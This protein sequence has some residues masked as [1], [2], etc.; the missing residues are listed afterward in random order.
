MARSVPYG[1][2]NFRVLVDNDE[3]IGGFSDVSGLSAEI[4]IAEYRPGNATENHVSKIPGVH[5]FENVTLKRGIVDSK[6]FWEWMRQAWNTGPAAKRDV[7]IQMLD[8]AHSNV[9]QWKLIGAVPMKYTGPSLAGA[10]GTE[11]AM[12]EWQ[13]A[14][15]TLEFQQLA[16]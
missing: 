8:E 13:I 1:N 14:Y 15:D 4:N 6:A 11:V 9:Q 5:K 2:F 7:L 16:S 12:E 3:V 10:G